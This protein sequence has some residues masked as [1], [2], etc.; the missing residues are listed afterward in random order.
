VAGSWRWL[1][2]DLVLRETPG[3]PVDRDEAG[4]VLA[5]AIGADLA[6]FLQADEAASR[7]LDRLS[8]LRQAMPELEWPD[9][10]G[11]PLARLV[12]SACAGC[13]SVEEVGGIVHVLR[14]SLTP[15][16]ARA[17]ESEAPETLT[18]PSGSR[19]K[20]SYDDGKPRLAARLQELFGWTETPR[21]AGGRVPVVLEL[22]G[23]NFRPVQV[24]EDLRSF[25]TT[26][27]AQVR[28]D[29]RNRYPR[30]AWPEDPW[31]ARAEAKGGPRRTAP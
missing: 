2:H 23:P 8:F 21:L 7:W 14:T 26:T 18:V 1:Y 15:I 6:G 5:R 28:K 17:V 31:T 24:T 9:L 10:E 19:I 27:Y 30:H 11:E 13:V 12:E 25:W 29:L 20:L 4:R 16:Q 3:A 22:L